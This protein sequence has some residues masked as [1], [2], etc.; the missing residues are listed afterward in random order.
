MEAKDTTFKCAND[1][2]A[3]PFKWVNPEDMFYV[4]RICEAQAEITWD[5]AVR[6]VVE[7]ADNRIEA[8]ESLLVCYRIG[9]HPTERLL[10]KLD[11]SG[12]DWQAKM[13]N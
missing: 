11:S 1:C 4:K 7:I 10:T 13:G 12:K 3:I 9:K 6:E 2:E 5:K 8:L